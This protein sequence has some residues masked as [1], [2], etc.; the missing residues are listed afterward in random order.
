M[1]QWPPRHVDASVVREPSKHL[2]DVRVVRPQKAVLLHEDVRRLLQTL[3]S[4]SVNDLHSTTFTSCLLYRL[5]DG[6][7]GPTA[8]EHAHVEIHITPSHGRADRERHLELL[9]L[10][11]CL[12]LW[13]ALGLGLEELDNLVAFASRIF[14]CC[15]VCRCFARAGFHS[16]GADD[17]PINAR[18]LF[19]QSLQCGTDLHPFA[20]HKLIEE[21]RR[22][23][24]EDEHQDKSNHRYSPHGLTSQDNNNS[25]NNNNNNQTNG[26]RERQEGPRWHLSRCSNSASAVQPAP[27]PSWPAGAE[28][29]RSF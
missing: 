14:T 16:P 11:A 12:G 5:V 25:S 23:M 27:R 15:W 28:A 29:H 21:M 7:E 1:S 4:V 24:I 22:R 2:D 6:G 26:E 19:E 10:C 18:S 9:V 13:C 17:D 3:A 20:F 8:Q